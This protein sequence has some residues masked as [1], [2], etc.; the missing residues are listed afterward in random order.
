MGESVRARVLNIGNADQPAPIDV[1]TR[2]DKAVETTTR[3][4]MRHKRSDSC[5]EK[6]KW[7]RSQLAS[8]DADKKEAA[9][10]EEPRV[11]FEKEQSEKSSNVDEK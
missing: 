7:I 9:I 1:P 2:S 6:S 5:E 8:R 11:V 3:K 4:R 10:V